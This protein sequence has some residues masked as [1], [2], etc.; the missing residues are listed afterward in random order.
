M[1]EVGSTAM[2]GPV[3]E[4]LDTL[5]G[6]LQGQEKKAIFREYTGAIVTLTVGKKLLDGSV[7][8][9]IGSTTVEV[10]KGKEKRELRIFEVKVPRL[11][12][13]KKP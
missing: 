6:I 13:G 3:P 2:K 9:G 8:T 1:T 12:T 4:S 11:R 10:K 7:I 5:I